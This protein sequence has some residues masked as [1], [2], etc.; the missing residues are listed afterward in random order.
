[1]CKEMI[2]INYVRKCRNLESPKKMHRRYSR[3][4][5]AVIFG[6]IER[7]HSLSTI[8]SNINR[9]IS[10]LAKHIRLIDSKNQNEAPSGNLTQEELSRIITLYRAGYTIDQICKETLRSDRSVKRIT[11]IVDMADIIK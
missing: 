1:M 7:G 8:A 5:D 11:D 6:M 3:E 2:N 4:E 9:P 10:G